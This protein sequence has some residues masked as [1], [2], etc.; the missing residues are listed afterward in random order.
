MSTY[1]LRSNT[2]VPAGSELL[3]T[4][5]GSKQVSLL[6]SQRPDRLLEANLLPD[7]DA[8]RMTRMQNP[9]R[10]TKDLTTLLADARPEE[11]LVILCDSQKIYQA[12][13]KYLNIR[14]PQ[15]T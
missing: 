9:F 8:V 4:H 6:I 2:R 12:A 13:L 15:P 5:F 1:S 3:T 10:V 11:T 14:T 7:G